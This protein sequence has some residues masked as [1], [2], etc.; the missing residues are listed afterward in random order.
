MYHQVGGGVGKDKLNS[1]INANLGPRPNVTHYSVTLGLGPRLR[2]TCIS[3]AEASEL[4]QNRRGVVVNYFIIV[5]KIH[6][7]K[8]IITLFN[9][10]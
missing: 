5:I 8:S 1:C 4:I 2:Y 9:R 10:S 7:C 3:I 6:I